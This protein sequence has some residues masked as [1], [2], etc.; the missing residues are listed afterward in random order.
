MFLLD[1]GIEHQQTSEVSQCIKL[2]TVPGT[3]RVCKY[4]FDLARAHGRKKVTCITKNNIMKIT[5]GMFAKVF[6]KMAS[7]YPDIETEHRIVD[8]AT[9]QVASKPHIFDVIVT[10]NLYGD[11]I[12]DVA[13][14]VAGSVGLCGSANIG[15]QAA[16]FEAVHGSAPDIAGKDIANPG[17]LLNGAVMMLT[18][19]G[20]HETA[21]KIKNA[22]LA[23]LEDGIHTA[24]IYRPNTSKVKVGTMG[25]SDAVIERLGVEPKIL[26][27]ESVTA[28][29][30]TNNQQPLSHYDVLSDPIT[31]FP[32]KELVGCDF[33][34]DWQGDNRN[35][36][37]LAKV[38]QSCKSDLG[39]QMISNR[40]V[41]VWPD[42][43]DETFKVNHWRCRFVGQGSTVNNKTYET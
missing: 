14:E 7:K 42:G 28:A 41:K 13:A 39:L 31:T 25:F 17:G 16:M 33:F 37:T 40:G 10:L 11:I 9:A 2:I 20:Q 21:V 4:A 32:Q 27:A 38:L 12:S 8:I 36:E 19:I 6:D 26:R 29:D 23:A 3:Q 30:H 35:P 43:H 22:F 15:E 5:D 18:H 24:D 34:V 1:A